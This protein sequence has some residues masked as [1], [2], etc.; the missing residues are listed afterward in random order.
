MSSSL[1]C[2]LPD[3]WQI[4]TKLS[5]IITLY[6]GYSQETPSYIPRL[7][8]HKRMMMCYLLKSFSEF[9]FLL[10]DRIVDLQSQWH[11]ILF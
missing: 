8:S 6:L 9:P 4:K 5:K 1:V 2:I 11:K 10:Y 3:T 7:L